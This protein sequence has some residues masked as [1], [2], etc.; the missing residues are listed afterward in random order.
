MSRVEIDRRARMVIGRE[1]IVSMMKIRDDSEFVA[2]LGADSL[3]MVTLV[4]A[5]EEEF[6]IEISDDDVAFCQTVGTAIDVI[7][8]KLE[9][10]GA[11]DR[12]AKR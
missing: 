10:G 7:A 6:R 3:D 12:R 1:L 11:L 9:N 8:A 2:H 4:A 5:L